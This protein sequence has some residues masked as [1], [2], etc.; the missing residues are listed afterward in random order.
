M[1][2]S[3]EAGAQARS[4]RCGFFNRRRLAVSRPNV[5]GIMTSVTMRPSVSIESAACSSPPDCRAHDHRVAGALQHALD[6]LADSL[7]VR[8]R[9]SS[10]A[11]RAPVPSRDAPRERPD[12]AVNSVGRDYFNP[13]MTDAFRA[14][15]AAIMPFTARLAAFSPSRGRL[16]ASARRRPAR[17]AAAPPGLPRSA[18]TAVRPAPA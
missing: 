3:A 10:A 18:G 1:N 4:L 15:T 2:A 7:L 9:E 16:R 11:P 17:S 12:A 8:S 13:C 14:G 6:E 5:S